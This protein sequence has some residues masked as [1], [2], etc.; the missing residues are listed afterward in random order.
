MGYYRNKSYC[1]CAA[2]RA[3]P[4]T[5]VLHK[6]YLTSSSLIQK[7]GKGTSYRWCDWT[8]YWRC[9]QLEITSTAKNRFY[10]SA[11]AYIFILQERNKSWGVL[12]ADTVVCRSCN[13]QCLSEKERGW[14]RLLTS[15]GNCA[16]RQILYLGSNSIRENSTHRI[17]SQ[18]HSNND[19]FFIS[20]NASLK[21]HHQSR[22]LLKRS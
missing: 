12:D 15:P 20:K 14:L 17:S 1:K 4:V 10:W 2:S 8:N 22:G 13:L 9:C 16:A 18:I 7:Q 19:I 5:F 11:M 3:F 6:T 21:G